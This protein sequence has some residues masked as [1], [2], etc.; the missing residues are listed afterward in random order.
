MTAKLT[1]TRPAVKNAA[2]VA[3]QLGVA[4]TLNADGSLTIVPAPSD[5]TASAKEAA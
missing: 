4:V 2:L 5:K 1:H 3:K